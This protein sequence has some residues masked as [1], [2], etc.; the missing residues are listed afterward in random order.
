MTGRGKTGKK[1]LWLDT[2]TVLAKDLVLFSTFMSGGSQFPLAPA[3]DILSWFL[4]VLC[5]CI[6]VHSHTHIH[7]QI[8][9]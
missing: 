8:K 1:V 9:N 6:H 7:T 2:Y 3:Q 4:V 5:M